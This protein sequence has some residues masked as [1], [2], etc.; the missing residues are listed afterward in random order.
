MHKEGFLNNVAYIS[1]KGAKGNIE[2]AEDINIAKE[3]TGIAS[4][5]TVLKKDN[6]PIIKA[7]KQ[8][9]E[10]KDIYYDF[11][12]WKLRPESEKILDKTTDLLEVNPDI[13]VQINS[14]SDERGDDYFNLKLSDNR[15][16][17][18]INYLIKKGVDSQGWPIKVGARQTFV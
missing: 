3:G 15:A 18:V 11:G 17:S 16:Q 4:S 12:R 1:T 13:K 8:E 10:I 5:K 6:M 7:T 9:V 2:L 14:H